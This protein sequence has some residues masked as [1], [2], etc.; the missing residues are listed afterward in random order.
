MIE[1]SPGGEPRDGYAYFGSEVRFAREH[2][3]STQAQLAEFTTY[4]VPYVSKVENGQQLGSELFAQG[5]DEYFNT[6]GYFTRLRRRVSQHGHP[7]WFVPYLEL[8]DKAAQI[9]DFSSYL[10]MGILQTPEYAE[11]LFR[12]A[13]PR[14]SAEVTKSKVEARLQRHGTMERAD[15]PL[16]WVVLDESCLRRV[17]GDRSVMYG[18][19]VHLLSEAENPHVTLQVLPFGTGAPPAAESFTLL[20][21]DDSPTVLYSEAQ[22]LGRVIDSARVVATGTSRY[23]RLRADALSPE[24]SLTMMRKVIEEYVR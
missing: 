14:D 18:Q 16:L 24:D 20:T 8:E 10:V 15:P 23:E 21:F 12:A 1:E 22:G 3:G 11:A 2:K 7:E 17:V 19:V 9:L 13:H 6:S 5:C 4:K